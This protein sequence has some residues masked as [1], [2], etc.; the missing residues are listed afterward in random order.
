LG[1]VS[2]D[3]F[4][5]EFCS[6]NVASTSEFCPVAALIFVNMQN[7]KYNGWVKSKAIPLQA[8][9]GPECFRS[10]RLPDLKTIGT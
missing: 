4:D 1:F 2:C 8:W 9:A 5:I 6:I 10:L 7:S 3:R